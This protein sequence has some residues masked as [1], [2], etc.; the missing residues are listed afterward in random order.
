MHWC[1]PLLEQPAYSSHTLVAIQD[2]LVTAKYQDFE[3]E[4]AYKGRWYNNVIG[5]HD[6][7]LICSQ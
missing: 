5:D 2:A 6:E 1:F 4:N 7:H 3:E